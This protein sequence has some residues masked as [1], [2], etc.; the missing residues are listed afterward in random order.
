M[1]FYCF[2]LFPGAVFVSLGVPTDDMILAD[3]NELDISQ[4]SNLFDLLKTSYGG[5]G[6]FDFAVPD[7]R[8]RCALGASLSIPLGNQNGSETVSLFTDHLP[9]HNHVFQASTLSSRYAQHG[10]MKLL[11]SIVI[12]NML[13]ATINLYVAPLNLV[14][15][16]IDSIS[17]IG[18][19]T[20]HENM[21]PYYAVNFYLLAWDTI[22]S[23]FSLF[24]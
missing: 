24:Y 10:F 13:A 4:Y 9:T 17:Y 19:S 8:G 21:Q 20:A 3:G 12:P 18:G 22:T 2:R 5:D 23:L 1:K 16:S 11:Y 15:V 7:M 14:E 6:V